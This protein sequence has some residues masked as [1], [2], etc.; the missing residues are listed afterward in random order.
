MLKRSSLMLA[1]ICFLALFTSCKMGE[2][3]TETQEKLVLVNV[4]DKP[5]YDDCHIKVTGNNVES[6]NV[7][8]DD[9]EEYAKKH[10][11]KEK[12]HIVVYCANYMCTASAESAKMLMNSGFKNVWAYEGGTAEWMNKGFSVSGPCKKGYLEQFAK[13]EDHENPA[14]VSVITAEDLKAKIE[15]FGS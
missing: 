6:V 9:I 4:L 14:G 10:W 11:D 1:G 7:S 2:K 13:P 15:K 8:M 3:K 5:L 12:T